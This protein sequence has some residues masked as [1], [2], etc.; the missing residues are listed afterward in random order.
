MTQAVNRD[1][2]AQVWIISD[3]KPGH[4]NQSRGL[5]D[6]LLRNRPDWQ[7]K[8]IPAMTFIQAVM[9]ALLSRRSGTQPRPELIIAAGHHTHLSALALGRKTGARTVVIMQPSL[10]T[11]WFDVALIPEHDQPAMQSNVILTK[12]ALNRMQPADKTA[13]SGMILIGGPSKHYGWDNETVITQLG[14][15]LAASPRHWL[16]TTSRRTP[17]DL[18][19]RL[20]ALVS[21]NVELLPFEKTGPDWLAQQL[22]KKEICWVTPDSVSMIYE[23]LTAGCRVG[24]FNLPEPSDSR[25]V[26]GLQSLINNKQLMTAT[27]DSDKTPSQTRPLDEASRCAQTLLTRFAL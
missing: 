6:A 9:T 23:A 2:V 27:D 17:G 26:K 18:L 5:A 20:Q 16:I 13:N 12:G 10:P 21:A 1:V 4:L 15:L 22:P 8:E 11:R 14:A 19:P 7:V 3:G 25:V 24:V